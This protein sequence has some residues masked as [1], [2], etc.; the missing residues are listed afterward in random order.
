MNTDGKQMKKMK[1]GTIVCIVIAA[2]LLPVFLI[3]MTLV[4]KGLFNG[5]EPPS[6][7]GK[8]PLAVTSGSMDT[9]KEDDIQVGDMI[10][11]EKVEIVDLKVNDIVTFHVGKDYIT[12]RIIEIAYKA[13]GVTVNYFIT[14]GDA[15]NTTDGHI[16][17]DQ[18]HGRYVKRIGFLGNVVLFLQSPWTLIVFLALPIGGYCL[19]EFV[20]RAGEKNKSEEMAEKDAEIERLRALVEAQK[21]EDNL[22]EESTVEAEKDAEDE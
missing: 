6:I 3:N 11:I 20:L 10:F 18:I 8:T 15:N 4:F 19:Y 9:G 13:D 16:Q 1:A 21:A 5:A 22:E 2:L 7:F 14:K 17:P 12:H